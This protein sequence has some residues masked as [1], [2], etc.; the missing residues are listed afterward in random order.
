MTETT[1]SR[2]IIFY[3][4]WFNSVMYAPEEKRSEILMAIMQYAFTGILPQDPMV[5]AVCN[6][7]FATIDR[8]T[9]K[10]E[11][12]K[13]RRADAAK[14]GAQTRN[15]GRKSATAETNAAEAPASEATGANGTKEASQTAPEPAASAAAPRRQT[16]KEPPKEVFLE[17]T[18]EEVKNFFEGCH[19]S[20][21]PKMFYNHYRANGWKIGNTKMTDWYAAAFLWEERQKSFIAQAK[22]MSRGGYDPHA[23]HRG[24][25]SAAIRHEDYTLGF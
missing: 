21:D 18:L 15:Y 1:Q 4:E 7:M 24:V 5:M 14:R 10:W 11:E 22:Q 3:E 16:T 17:P 8:D 25:E 20:S 13:E 23:R 2:R 19:F 9:T 12:T 6:V